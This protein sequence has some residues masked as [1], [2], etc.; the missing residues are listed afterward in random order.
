MPKPLT[1]GEKETMTVHNELDDEMTFFTY[2][3]SYQRLM[4]EQFDLKPTMDNGY[5]GKEY[6]MSKRWFRVPRRP[7]KRK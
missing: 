6:T 1:R 2:R 7:R 4:E 3:K 5:G